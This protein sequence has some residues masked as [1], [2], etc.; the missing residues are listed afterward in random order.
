VNNGSDED[1]TIQRLLN[2]NSNILERIKHLQ[3][4]IGTKISSLVHAGGPNPTDRP[5][6]SVIPQIGRSTGQDRTDEVIRA[7]NVI[8]KLQL[9]ITKQKKDETRLRKEI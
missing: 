7:E 9:R 4:A 1:P 2:A 6:H 5:N 8:R 3:S